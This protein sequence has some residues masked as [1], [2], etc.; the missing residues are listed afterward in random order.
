MFKRG[1]L[2]RE[3]LSAYGAAGS[4]D[5]SAATVTSWGPH[6]TSGSNA[7]SAQTRSISGL[8]VAGISSTL[9]VHRHNDGTVV[10]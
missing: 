8:T 2:G 6:Y 9:R 4:E 1:K 7:A 5:P 3:V 10:G